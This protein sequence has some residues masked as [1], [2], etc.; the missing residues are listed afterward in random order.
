MDEGIQIAVL[1]L[2]RE[3]EGEFATDGA[4]SAHHREAMLH[5]AHVVVG[6]FE[7]EQ[8]VR[9]HRFW[10]LKKSCRLCAM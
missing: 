7:D 9:D 3:A 1:Q 6:H 2:E 10:P 4:E 8:V 5:V